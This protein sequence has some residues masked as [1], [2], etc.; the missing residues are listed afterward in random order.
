MRLIYALVLIA[1]FNLPWYWYAAACAVWLA[2]LAFAHRGA[3][4]AR[5]A[6]DSVRR[7]ADSAVRADAEAARLGASVQHVRLT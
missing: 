5:A 2:G 3:L 4:V 7:D 6:A 1:G